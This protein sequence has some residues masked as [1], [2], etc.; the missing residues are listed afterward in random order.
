MFYEEDVFLFLGMFLLI[1][2]ENDE[3]IE[4]TNRG[5]IDVEIEGEKLKFGE[6]S[7]TGL[8][9]FIDNEKNDTIGYFYKARISNGYDNYDDIEIYA[10]FNDDFTIDSL[11]VEFTSIKN[12]VGYTYNYNY[13][14]KP[15][16]FSNINYNPETSWLTANFEGYLYRGGVL[17]DNK[18]FFKNGKISVPLKGL[19]IPKNY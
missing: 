8:I 13:P 3:I 14:E 1:S 2:C 7:Y 6:K 4:K 15:L 9:R 17:E 16:I 12:G 5:T 11:E 10:Y 19:D 18:V